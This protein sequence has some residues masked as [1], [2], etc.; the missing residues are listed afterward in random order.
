MK[1]LILLLLPFFVFGCTI[2]SVDTENINLRVENLSNSRLENIRVLYQVDTLRFGDLAIGSKSDY[3][4]YNDGVTDNPIV[5]AEY[6]GNTISTQSLLLPI[7]GEP[8]EFG[9]YTI[10]L[11]VFGFEIYVEIDED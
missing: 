11:Q 10:E 1:N 8:L 6:F 2:S 9:S 4:I 5:V 3:Q 7:A